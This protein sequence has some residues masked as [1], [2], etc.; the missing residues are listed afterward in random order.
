MQFVN[1]QLDAG[2]SDSSYQEQFNVNAGASD[3]EIGNRFDGGTSDVLRQ[4]DVNG[5][6][7]SK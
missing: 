1:I 6:D 2:H 7:S 3:S 4:N 5:G